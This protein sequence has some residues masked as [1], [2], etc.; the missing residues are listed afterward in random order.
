M[1]PPAGAL[2]AT[3]SSSQRVRRLGAALLIALMAA[4]VG[5]C[6]G[7]EEPSGTGGDTSDHGHTRAHRGHS[8]HQ[9]GRRARRR[10]P[11]RLPQDRGSGPATITFDLIQFFTGEAATKA[12]A[13]D[14]QGSPAPNDYYIRNVNPRLRTLPVRADAPIR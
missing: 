3:S 6:G 5:G 2:G 4:A 11:S 13:E 9:R 7:S 10:P 8:N 14:G 1:E 12:A